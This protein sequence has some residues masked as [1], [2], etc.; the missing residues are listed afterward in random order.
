MLHSIVL[1]ETHL[2][3]VQCNISVQST[4]KVLRYL[5]TWGTKTHQIS[6]ITFKEF[7]ALKITIWIYSI[8]KEIV[9]ER[10]V[11]NWKVFRHLYG[12]KL[13]T[14]VTKAKKHIFES[15]DFWNCSFRQNFH[16][17]RVNHATTELL[18]SRRLRVVSNLACPT[19]LV[20]FVRYIVF[21][22]NLRH[23]GV[24]RSYEHLS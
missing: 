3:V 14:S 24:Y 19:T 20:S 10:A 15:V 17:A 11:V 8:D 9:V 23:L 16:R 1:K 21:R 2:I 5:S 12:K 4:S 18:W 7:T 6:D 13:F 22:P